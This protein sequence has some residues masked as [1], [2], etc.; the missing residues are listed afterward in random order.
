M[1]MFVVTLEEVDSKEVDISC[2]G[3]I[4]LTVIDFRGNSINLA[5]P[6]S[7]AYRKHNSGTTFE[8]GK[9]VIIIGFGYC[10][11]FTTIWSLILS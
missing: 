4:G 11:N 2:E 5:T 6:C 8:D 7:R 10:R 1:N 3:R 9:G